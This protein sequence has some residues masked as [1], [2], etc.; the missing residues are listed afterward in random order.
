MFSHG[1]GRT[2]LLRVRMYGF[3]IERLARRGNVGAVDGLRMCVQYLRLCCCMGDVGSD[4]VKALLETCEQVGELGF[5][6]AAFRR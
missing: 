4:L 6:A 3:A 1:R 5:F 2:G